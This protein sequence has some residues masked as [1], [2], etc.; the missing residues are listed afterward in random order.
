MKSI[1]FLNPV[2][3]ITYGVLPGFQENRWNTFLCEGDEFFLW[4]SSKEQYKILNQ[5]IKKYE[6]DVVFLDFG[7]GPDFEIIHKCCKENEAKLVLWGIEDTPKMCDWIDQT[8]DFCDI[9]LTT[10]KEL[11]PY[12]KKKYNKDIYLMTF[13]INPSIH[14]L[15]N[16]NSDFNHDIVFVGNNY[17]SRYD[18]FKDYII[19][20]IEQKRD[21][22]IW[23]SNEWLNPKLDVSLCQYPTI[24][25]GYFPYEKL[26][27]L[28]ASSKVA[29]GLNCDKCSI[30]QTSMRPTEVMAIGH[31]IY[32]APYSLAQE[33]LFGKS[34]KNCFLPKTPNEMQDDID[35][36]LN[37]S[38]DERLKIASKAQQMVYKKHNY[39]DKIAD[40]I[41]II[42]EGK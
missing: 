18:D 10:T 25:Q 1:L 20:L 12:A 40:L 13:G 4:K 24:F 17:S 3:L 42:E 8:I 16:K 23:G 32:V 34:G 29:L 37:M 5:C 21:I 36:V 41:K 28:Y 22:A 14:K 2:P 11:I 30:T 27:D 39:K 38:E 26:V 7:V 31:A 15:G 6:I 19:P 33:Y 9:Y 35:Y